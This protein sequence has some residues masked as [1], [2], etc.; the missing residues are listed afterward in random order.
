MSFSYIPETPIFY[1]RS[2]IPDSQAPGIFSDEEITGFMFINSSVWQSS[3]VFSYTAGRYL[4]QCPSNYFRA[5]AI[6]LNTLAGNASRLAGVI[7]LLD[8][9]LNN[10]LAAKALQDTANAY[11]AM[12]DNSGACAIA[13]QVTTSWNFRDRWRA[14]LQRQTGGIA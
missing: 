9:K 3:M 6:A 11:L 2:L 5:A 13:E 8:V 1:V 7:G 10:A 12:D 4:P 14:M